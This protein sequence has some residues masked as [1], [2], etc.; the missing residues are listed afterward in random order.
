MMGLNDVHF[1]NLSLVSELQVKKEVTSIPEIPQSLNLQRINSRIRNQVDEKKRLLTSMSSSVTPE[2]QR[3]FVTIGKT[4]KDIRW[5]NTDIVVWD[6][7]VGCVVITP[8]YQLEDIQGNSNSMEYSYIRKVVEKHMK[9][10]TLNSSQN[11]Q[12]IQHNS[13]SQ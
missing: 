8:P 12:V 11:Q 9:D 5:R 3:L 13:N 1:I 7:Q 4:I 2:G 6:Q 10:T